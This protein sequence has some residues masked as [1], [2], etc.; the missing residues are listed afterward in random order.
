MLLFLRIR[1]TRYWL[2]F[3]AHPLVAV[4]AL[5]LTAGLF[6]VL[7]A[8]WHD[9]GTSDT[10]AAAV[11]AAWALPFA[12]AWLTAAASVGETSPTLRALGAAAEDDGL[13]LIVAGPLVAIY[14]LAVV[15]VG[16]LAVVP[17]VLLYARAAQARNLDLRDGRAFLGAA[18]LALVNALVG[19]A[20]FGFVRAS[21]LPLQ[22]V[23]AVPLLV[24]LGAALA[25]A[26][27]ALRRRRARAHLA[28]TCQHVP[29]DDAARAALAD[30][31]F[32]GPGDHPT[33]TLCTH[34][35]ATYRT[36][37]EHLGYF[38]QR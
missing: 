32:F 18:L 10:V 5:T 36:T 28:A 35:S 14:V 20:Y 19:G 7:R 13:L 24:A 34:A 12:V 33:H 22:T 11:V 15:L 8:G 6:T 26:G 3:R 21:A 37:P 31:P 27:S 23:V 1:A 4:G 16:M 38:A 9:R 17:P 25:V 2:T 30:A 29:L